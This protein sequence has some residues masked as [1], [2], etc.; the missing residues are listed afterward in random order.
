MKYKVINEYEYK[1]I[2]TEKKNR[3]IWHICCVVSFIIYFFKIDKL[4]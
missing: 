2:K 3:H 4:N 1:K